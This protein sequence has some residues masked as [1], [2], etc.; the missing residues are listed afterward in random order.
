MAIIRKALHLEHILKD[1]HFNN[2]G[3]ILLVMACLMIYFTFNI[4]LVEIT[5]NEPAI[6]R[7]VLEKV[8][9]DYKYPFWG[10]IGIGFILPAIILAFRKGRTVAGCVVASIPIVIAMWIERYAI[11]APTLQHPRLPWAHGFYWPSWVEVAITAGCLAA[12]V[13]LYMLFS[14]FFPI[15][16]VWEV[17]EGIDESIPTI[18][19]CYEGYMPDT[20]K[21]EEPGLRRGSTSLREP[22]PRR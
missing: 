2:L 11:I 7:A 3:L 22:R 13:F 14:K 1:I 5:G 15:V 12:F 10:M 16:S 6:M 4:Y 19:K 9:G 8:H 21:P 17:Q 18:T 20:E